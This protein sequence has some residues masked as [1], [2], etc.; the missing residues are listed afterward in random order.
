MKSHIQMPRLI[1]RNFT[2]QFHTLH[3]Y[4][5][6]NDRFG[7]C[8]PKSFYT[9]QDY[10]S[11]DVESFW[12]KEIESKLGNMIKFLNDTGLFDGIPVPAEFE[13]VSRN[14]VMSLM[15][16][17]PF[18]FDRTNK[19]SVYL[20]FLSLQDQHDY[21]AVEAYNMLKRHGALDS[22]N[23]A[24]LDNRSSEE[25]IL[26]TGG[27]T[28]VENHLICPVT[29]YKAILLDFADSLEDTRNTIVYTEAG[30]GIIRKINIEAFEQE[31]NRD[32]KF[33]VATNENLL[34]SVREDYCQTAN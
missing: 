32:K 31:M 19:S 6:E 8:S 11:K 27:I 1:L 9:G 20:Q 34:K 5:Y 22:C 28:Q 7:K 30:S 3:Y 18:L 13:E 14:Y 17:S 29:P 10:Y 26:P 24:F 16:R 33:V 21:T 23:I 25:F 2:D 15:G 12:D 4:D